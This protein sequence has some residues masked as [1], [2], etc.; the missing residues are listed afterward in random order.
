MFCWKL[1][2]GFDR[3]CEKIYIEEKVIKAVKSKA[4]DFKNME[5]LGLKIMQR[6]RYLNARFINDFNELASKNER[7]FFTPKFAKVLVGCDL[8]LGRYK[9]LLIFFTNLQLV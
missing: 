3:Y 6:Y 5:Y 7:L 2:R 8:F 1:W 4:F 9:C